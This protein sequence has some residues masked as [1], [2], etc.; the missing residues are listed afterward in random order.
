VASGSFPLDRA[1]AWESCRGFKAHGVEI[2]K[3][4]LSLSLSPTG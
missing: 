4:S 2:G 1:V 3:S